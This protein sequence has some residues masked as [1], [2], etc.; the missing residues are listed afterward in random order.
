MRY[1]IVFVGTR[2]I[3]RKRELTR[4]GFSRF[5]AGRARV[6]ESYFILTSRL[7]LLRLHKHVYIKCDDV[8]ISVLYY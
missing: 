2:I 8:I 4:G 7:K 3:R 1:I 5:A 6:R